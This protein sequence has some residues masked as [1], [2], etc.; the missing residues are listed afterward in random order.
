LKDRYQ[1]N[2]VEYTA[3]VHQIDALESEANLPASLD[4]ALSAL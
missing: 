1:N 2:V 4:K 3:L